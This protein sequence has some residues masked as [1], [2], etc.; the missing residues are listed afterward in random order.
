MSQRRLDFSVKLS[1]R[2]HLA[3]LFTV[4]VLP[5]ITFAAY[6]LDEY[7]RSER[8]RQQQVALQ[9]AQQGVALVDRELTELV[10]ALQAL[11]T[12]PALQPGGDLAA[13]DAQARALNESRAG[14][15]SVRDLAG[16]RLVDTRHPYGAALPQSTPPAV[17]E[18]DRMVTQTG[19][20]AVSDLH[21]EAESERAVI[22]VDAPV[23]GG[24]KIVGFLDIAIDPMRLADILRGLAPSDWTM[25]IV[26]RGDRVVARSRLHDRFIGKTATADLRA[27]TTGAFGTWVGVNLEGTPVVNAYARSPLSGWRVAVG[28]PEEIV[29]APIR[30]ITGALIVASAF[31]VALC[32]ILAMAVARGI[33]DPLA[34]L[35]AAA[36]DLGQGRVVEPLRTGA[37]EIDAVS[38]ALHRASVEIHEREAALRAGERHLQALVD[39]LNHRVKNTLASVQ[40]IAMQT[41]RGIG[42]A[43]YEQFERRVMAL[44]EAHNLLSANRWSGASLGDITR[45]ILGPFAGEKGGR[46]TIR[47]DEVMLPPKACLAFALALQEL[48]SNAAKYGALSADGRI[49]VDWHVTNGKLALYWNETGGP[50]VLPPEKQGFGTRLVSRILSQDLDDGR[51]AF[52]FAPSGLRVSVTCAI[53]AGDPVEPERRQG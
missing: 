27:K 8:V 34:K 46:V 32:A 33:A 18:L 50:T 22:A 15:V 39:E 49:D 4:V 19:R 28:V 29:Y 12:S 44:S 38:T 1:V 9:L 21:V 5:I 35:E 17:L 51:V 20:P 47:G 37:S 16:R 7:A 36:R 41:L 2:A 26:D 40:S 3:L 23:F 53:P 24:G 25:A 14:Y 42:R 10:A 13:F 45:A 43:E 48:A 52:D 30:G 11:S 31:V 6:L